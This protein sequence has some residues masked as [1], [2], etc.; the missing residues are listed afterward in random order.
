MDDDGSLVDEVLGY[1]FSGSVEERNTRWWGK[2]AAVD[3]EI[4]ERFADASA[5]AVAG[6]LDDLAD[7]PWGCLAVIVLLD[8]VPRT[9]YRDTARMFEGDQRAVALTLHLLEEGFVD[10]LDTDERLFAVLPLEHSEALAH[11]DRALALFDAWLGEAS[12]EEERAALTYYRDYSRQ[13]RDI[14][15]RFGRFPH[16]N[17][18]LG[19]ESTAEELAFLEQPGSSF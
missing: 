19:R 16:R 1:W 14:V 12:T 2:S 5:A 15:A 9:L 3:A 7:D 10:D 13:H 18:A 6:E 17:A 8:Q 11:Q 4:G